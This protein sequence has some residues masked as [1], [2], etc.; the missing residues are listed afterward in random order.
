MQEVWYDFVKPKYGNKQPNY[1]IWMQTVLWTTRNI[2]EDIAKVVQTNYELGRPQPKGKNKKVI[3]LMKDEIGGE[4]MKGF[5][6][7]RAKT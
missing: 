3:G 7:L 5:A 1:V 2:Y 6:A 4:I